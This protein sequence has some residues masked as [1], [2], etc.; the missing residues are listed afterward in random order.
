MKAPS[1]QGSLRDA[2]IPLEHLAAEL[3]AI[4]FAAPEAFGLA[5]T[6][7]ETL[8][9]GSRGATGRLWRAAEHDIVTAF[10]AFSIDEIVA[11]RDWLWFKNTC[12]ERATPE[13]P[14]PPVTLVEYLREISLKT[15]VF[16][17]NVYRPKL[18]SWAEQ[19]AYSTGGAPDARARRFWRWISYALPPDLLIAAHPGTEAVTAEIELVSP[20]LARMLAGGGYTEPHLHVGSA[21]SFD[22][23]WIGLMHVLA[24]P[25]DVSAM[26]FASP[27]AEANE[28]AGF[29][30][31]LL[32]A[33]LAR[34]VLAAYLS[35]RQHLPAL[36]SFN[37][38]LQ[39]LVKPFLIGHDVLLKDSDG[40]P[41]DPL[42]HL[43]SSGTRA[44]EDD[45][46][47]RRLLHASV[48]RHHLRDDADTWHILSVM[49]RGLARGQIGGE[50][51][52]DEVDL[53]S[54]QNTY[55]RLTRVRA[56]WPVFPETPPEA[57]AADP[58]GAMFPAQGRDLATSEIAFTRAG[59]RYLQ[60]RGKKDE[61]FT[62]LFWQIQRVRTRF[63]RHVVQR[64]MTP[65]LQ[66]FVRF[67][68]RLRG[69]RQLISP[70]LLVYE[71]ARACGLGHGLQ[72]LELRTSPESTAEATKRRVEDFRLAFSVL[73]RADRKVPG[74]DGKDT[75]EEDATSWTG[76]IEERRARSVER[77]TDAQ[78]D[79]RHAEFG[80]VLHFTRERGGEWEKGCPT[81]LGAESHADPTSD[82]NLGM[83]YAAY[84]RGKRREAQSVATMLRRYPRSLRV[85]RGLDVCT[86][87]LG[88]PT[89]VL[90]PLCRY[91]RDVSCAT[92]DYLRREFGEN[93]APLRLT[94]HAGEDFTHLLG[95]L[96]RVDEA[97]TYF[98]LAQGDRIGHAMALGVH[99][100]EWCRRAG[101]VAV[102]RHERL[103]DLAWEWR[104]ATD[105]EID[106][107]ANR[108]QYIIDQIELL[109]R[110]IFREFTHP[111]QVAKFAEYLGDSRLLGHLAF[112]DGPVPDYE[113]FL[114]V[115]RAIDDSALVQESALS[116]R[117]R[118]ER[119]VALAAA[120]DDKDRRLLALEHALCDLRR[121]Q[122][123]PQSAHG[124]EPWRLFYRYLTDPRAFRNGQ[125][126]IPVN[127]S[128]EEQSL[129][130][131][132]LALRRKVGAKGITVEINP[133][134]NLLIGNLSDLKNHPLWRLKPPVRDEQMGDIAVTIGTDNPITFMS[135]T[136]QEYQL[137]YDTLTLAGL[138]DNVARGWIDD[139]RRAGLESRFTIGE[140]ADFSYSSIW[141]LMDVDL[142]HL[143]QLR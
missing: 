85:L 25:E 47:V 97:L 14:N 15:L 78:S 87:E 117:E 138:S 57:L 21:I 6:E 125:T 27:G 81:A 28:G 131:L 69:P 44:P 33:A 5:L 109:S 113:E 73:Q 23:L 120:G 18:P 114:A 35:E 3:A 111:P 83:R 80:L 43:R 37:E 123:T 42:E 9:D 72:A 52:D 115:A 88:M 141:E 126:L 46:Q 61:A 107:T 36:V 39:R 49:L 26:T 92:S 129:L 116:T 34:Y 66:W 51:H 93:I 106:L 84:Y 22:M 67:F 59:L 118:V 77:W 12:P 96:R 24:R 127:P 135:G 91:V 76:Q 103:L 133:S 70:Q 134:S 86:D 16:A 142:S 68:R 54:A 20:V 29:T 8:K 19:S 105:N 40:S 1:H 74:G 32:H 11:M 139:C 79:N 38:Y 7:F 130:D 48:I 90:A 10:P 13:R 95:G 58:I 71:A 63:Y 2:A 98:E 30:R 45:E 136:R 128:I 55:A 101:A 60:G 137:I 89:W 119:E 110:D 99:P 143:A 17:G 140:A 65:G 132:Q 94:V 56:R 62:R 53:R 31:L 50:E 108:L 112:P 75:Q 102:T 41:G 104:F 121:K 100:G 64:P 122:E 82:G 4:P 124:E